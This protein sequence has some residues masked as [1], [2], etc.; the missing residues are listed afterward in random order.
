MMAQKSE[1]GR[2]T[3][4]RHSLAPHHP[5]RGAVRLDFALHRRYMRDAMIDAFRELRLT[6]SAF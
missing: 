2:E 4:P 3:R 5:L 6:I 1:D